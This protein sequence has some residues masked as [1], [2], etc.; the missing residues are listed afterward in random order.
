M[1]PT[2]LIFLEDKTDQRFFFVLHVC[3]CDEYLSFAWTSERSVR[4]RVTVIHNEEC[5]RDGIQACVLYFMCVHDL[6]LAGLQN[7]WSGPIGKE[8]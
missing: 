1:G 7:D 6:A 3:A 8:L 2:S 4:V 5:S